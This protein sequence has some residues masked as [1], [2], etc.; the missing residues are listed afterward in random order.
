MENETQVDGATNPSEGVA[1]ETEATT[2]QETVETPKTYSE[3]EF[4]QVVARAKKAEAEAKTF[5]VQADGLKQ[6][7]K[8]SLDVEDYIDISASLE[9]LDSKEKERLA[10][11]HKLS[12]RPLNEIRKD[13]DFL[14]WQSAY[15]QKADKE[16]ASLVPSSKQ[17]D[18]NS[19]VSLEDA[20]SGATMEEKEELLRN[21]M[22]YSVENKPRADRVNIGR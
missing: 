9:G 4:R 18:D 6:A 2:E 12:G 10:R 5:K 20:L 22:G 13:E 3:D 11:E 16:R 15:R 17:P 14:L 7:S 8:K 19:P 1:T 21:S